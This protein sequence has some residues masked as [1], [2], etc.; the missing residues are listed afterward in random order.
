MRTVTSAILAVIAAATVAACGGS[1]SASGS[2]GLTW[3]C[4][5]DTYGHVTVVFTNH[6]GSDIQ[7]DTAPRSG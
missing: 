6:T 3:T 5:M 2:G 7:V 4:A 1:T